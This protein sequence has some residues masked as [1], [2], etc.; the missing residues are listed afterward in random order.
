VDAKTNE[1][2]AALK[3]LKLIPLQGVLVTG[4]AAFTQKDFSQDIIT[5]GGDYFLTVKDNQP[6]LNKALLDAFVAPV[7]PSGDSGA[8]GRFAN[9]PLT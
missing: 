3:L 7:S 8:A 6:G 1:H 2:K 9:S 5:R 4:D